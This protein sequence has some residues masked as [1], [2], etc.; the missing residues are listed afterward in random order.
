MKP[1]PK[2]LLRVLIVWMRREGV[3]PTRTRLVKFLYL[4]DLQYARSH[5]GET[6][7]GWNWY[8]DSFGP[9]AVEA[10]RALDR[11]VEEHWLIPI[12]LGEREMAETLPATG[13]ELAER[14]RTAMIYD[15]PERSLSQNEEE[16]MPVGSG[17]LKGWMRDYG[18]DTN[19]L[20]RFIYGNTEPME[21]AIE[22]APLDFS[23]AQTPVSAH[24]IVSSGLKKKEKS[25]I[26]GLLKSMREK[27]ETALA[28]NAALVQGP[29]DD[30][31]SEG[32]PTE[33]DEIRG[34]AILT[35]TKP[36]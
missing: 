33:D 24:P 29:Y 15:L 11:G 13:L 6:I 26:A 27:Y 22:G 8:V 36:N 30:A 23:V 3:A 12:A 7:T 16:A 19:A 34:T 32:L 9:F 28:R 14:S 31:Y 1:D 18:S 35:F 5:R 4:A 20:L 21:F 10:L 2:T 25:K 17:K